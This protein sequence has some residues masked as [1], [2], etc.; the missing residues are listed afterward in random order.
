MRLISFRTAPDRQPQAGLELDGTALPAVGLMRYAQN[1]LNIPIPP[2][3][4]GMRGVPMELVLSFWQHAQPGLSAAHER[5]S[6]DP[7]TVD[8]MGHAIAEVEV[9]SP[10]T[11]PP[12][13]RDFY[14]FEE[15]VRRGNELR[16]RE[17][18]EAWYDL[19]VFYFTHPG[20]LHGPGQDVARPAG[21][22]ML[23]FELEAAWVIGHRGSDVP[24]EEAWEHIVG[25]TVMNDWSARDL[26][27]HEMQVGLGPSK[28]KDFATSLG[29]A[30]VT[31]DELADRRDGEHLELAM[32]ARRN[33]KQ[34]SQ[35][36][37][38][39]LHWTIPQMTAHASKAS[40]IQPGDVMG[41]GTVGTGSMLDLG[42]EDWL[43]PG[44]T[45]ELEI[46]RIGTLAN[47]VVER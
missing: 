26:Q 44:D 32:T 16:G 43:E 21:V 40:V 34:I 29:P 30:I 23:D 47:T 11:D 5:L 31:M 18:P 19:P 12:S 24:A 17:I 9:V 35:G 28:G 22:Q 25:L 8:D 14:A 27:A 39:D 13:V 42:A 36:N 2:Q 3:L 4:A 7:G 10:V 37:L 15:H 45:L 20:V 6:D 1:D 41:S 33:G 46:E 38:A